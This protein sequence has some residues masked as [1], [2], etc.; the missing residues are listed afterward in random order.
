M[1]NYSIAF[2]CTYVVSLTLSLTSCDSSSFFHYFLFGGHCDRFVYVILFMC[3]IWLL[4][5]RMHIAHTHT[6]I[7][8]NENQE[9]KEEEKRVLMRRKRS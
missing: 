5:S 6:E 4:L 8:H 9:E 1:E 2:H 3:L 7:A